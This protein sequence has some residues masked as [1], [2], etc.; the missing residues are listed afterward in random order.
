MGQERGKEVD[1]SGSLGRVVIDGVCA[2]GAEEISSHRLVGPS[3]AG[4]PLSQEEP[5]TGL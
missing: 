2:G 3:A 5:D 1:V 4:V